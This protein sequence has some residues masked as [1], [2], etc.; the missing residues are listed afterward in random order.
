MHNEFAWGMLIVIYL[1]TAGLSAGAMVTSNSALLFGGE[2]YARIG[3]WG[4]YIAPFPIA[5]GTGMLLLDLGSPFNFYHLFL[6]LQVK[7]PMSYG[8]WSILL[9]T[10]LSLVYFYLWLPERYQFWSQPQRAVHWQRLLAKVM[11]ILAVIV[12]SYTGVLLNAAARPLWQTPLLPE[13]FLV[14][15]FST[16][17]AAVILAGSLSRRWRAKHHELH[18]LT[19]VDVVLVVIELILFAAMGL[20]AQLGTLSQRQAFA[21][22]L[23]GHYAWMFWLLIVICGLVIPL[24]LETGELKGK[25]SAKWAG[26]LAIGSSFLVLFGG[27][28]VRYVIT[29]AG[30][31]T[32]W[33]R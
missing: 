16:G 20:S 14:S 23:Y 31:W 8:S 18:I 26:S 10:L 21:Q 33:V 3:R 17:I 29:Y 25:V 19:V 13:L 28:F 7:S 4:A 27:F 12:A 9:F 30:Q 22:L 11:P 6:Q 32:G 15:A 5:L 24:V 2:K 1:F